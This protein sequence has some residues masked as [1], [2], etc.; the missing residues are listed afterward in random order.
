MLPQDLEKFRKGERSGFDL[1]FREHAAGVRRVVE[2]FMKSAFEQDDALQDIWLVVW[3]QSAQYTPEKGALDGWLNALAANRSRDLLRAR[4]REPVEYD[5]QADAEAPQPGPE[6]VA[7]QSELQRALDE[8][9][10]TLDADEAA[11][12]KAGALAGVPHQDV[13]AA[14]GVSVRQSKYLKKKLLARALRHPK[15]CQVVGA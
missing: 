2:R 7:R 15:L 13:A 8:F 4:G 3:R 5:E 14:L 6:E 12:L 1:V 9:A 11:A 10:K